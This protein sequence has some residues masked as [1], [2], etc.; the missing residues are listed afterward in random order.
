[1]NVSTKY[2]SIDKDNRYDLFYMFRSTLGINLSILVCL[3]SI[4]CG[5]TLHCVTIKWFYED[6]SGHLFHFLDEN[7]V[8]EKCEV[9]EKI[10]FNNSSTQS[11]FIFNSTESNTT[12]SWTLNTFSTT[13]NILV[14]DHENGLFKSTTLMRIIEI[15]T[16]SIYFLFIIFSATIINRFNQLRQNLSPRNESPISH[17]SLENE[18]TELNIS[19]KIQQFNFKI[20]IHIIFFLSMFIIFVL[21]VSFQSFQIKISCEDFFKNS[22]QYVSYYFK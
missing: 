20:L 7:H 18:R 17:P 3:C 14:H 1:M 9:P 19:D 8:H 2:S 4:L 6:I 12:K 22:T 13:S 5:L 16:N 21:S 10:I 15:L 11:N